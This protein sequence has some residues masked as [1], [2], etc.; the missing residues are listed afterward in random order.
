MVQCGP[1]LGNNTLRKGKIMFSIGTKVQIVLPFGKRQ[2]EVVRAGVVVGRLISG[3]DGN[4]YYV[5]TVT[6]E[7]VQYAESWVRR[8]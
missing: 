5:R 4:T 8:G 1:E 7:V 6:G 3:I 2:G